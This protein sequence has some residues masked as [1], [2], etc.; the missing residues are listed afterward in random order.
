MAITSGTM[1]RGKVLIGTDMARRWAIFLMI[2]VVMW[3]LA[4]S[5]AFF[6]HEFSH[7]FTA[8]ALGWKDNP[9]A[10]NWGPLSPMN[11]LLHIDID[12]N[13]DYRPIFGGG[14]AFDAGLIA[15]AGVV[16]GNAVISLGTGLGT[17]MFAEKRGR[18]ALGCFAY[19][20]VVMSIGNL[21]S[22][23]PLRVFASHADMHIVALGFGWTPEQ[24][25][26]FTGIP[27]FIAALWFFLRFQPRALSSLFPES[28]ARCFFLVILTAL[29]VFGWFSLG[30]MFGYGE[31]S[32]K[33]SLAFLFGLTPIS[34]ILG[35]ILTRKHSAVRHNV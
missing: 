27:F 4:H 29:T 32:H 31:P 28:T 1:A 34:M 24:V 16:L 20:L 7:S 10:L 5:V 18:I 14:H 15:L 35:L 8:V 12:E 30:G 3:L 2:T 33:L 6:S 21:L 17:F 26:I 11:L 25:L 13:V 22:Y 9:L 19:W 23:V